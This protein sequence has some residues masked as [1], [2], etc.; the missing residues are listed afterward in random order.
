MVLWWQVA[1][2]CCILILA[3]IAVWSLS[4]RN[5]VCLSIHLP[6]QTFLCPETC[7]SMPTWYFLKYSAKY[8]L[9]SQGHSSGEILGQDWLWAVHLIIKSPWPGVAYVFSLF[10]PRPP[11]CLPP[12]KLFPLTSKPFELNLSH[13]GQRLY[14]SGEMYGMTFPWPWRKVTAVAFSSKNL[15]ARTLKWEPLITTN[16]SSI[17]ALVMVITWLDIREVGLETVILAN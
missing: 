17:I 6:I 1:W 10:L 4:Y 15:L 13:L 16:C 2:Y 3:S 11:P 5:K 14:K 8:F 7:L 9:T 12:L